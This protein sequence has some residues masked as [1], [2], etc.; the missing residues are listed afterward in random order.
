M[1]SIT[2]AYYAILGFMEQ[3][4]DVLWLIAALTFVMWTMIIERFWYFQGE[5]KRVVADATEVWE[6]RPERRSWTAHQIRDMLISRASMQITGSMGLINTCVS[7]CP[8]LGLLGTVT[9]MISV[10]DA[11]ATQGGNARS[12]A[13]GVSM[14]TIPTMAGMVASLSGVFATTFLKRKIEF[15]VELFQDHLTMDH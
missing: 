7:L 10:F 3:G 14:A 15:E 2:E 8:L 1:Q 6:D 12:M 11:M 5:H 4:G 9:G 13:A